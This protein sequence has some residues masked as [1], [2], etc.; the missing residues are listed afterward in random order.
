MHTAFQYHTLKKI[1]ETNYLIRCTINLPMHTY[2]Q[3]RLSSLW[4][5]LACRGRVGDNSLLM[6]FI[7]NESVAIAILWRLST[8]TVG[9]NSL[10]LNFMPSV[11][12]PETLR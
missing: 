4:A 6:A 3:L 11:L 5:G 10:G 9:V 8:P 12:D 7:D 2:K 1:G